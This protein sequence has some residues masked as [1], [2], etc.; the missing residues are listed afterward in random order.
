MTDYIG[1]KNFDKA[2]TVIY[3]MLGKGETLPRILNSVYN[4]FRRLLHVAISNNTDAELAKFLGIKEFA[5]K[6]AK[7][8]ANAFKK[9]SLKN[10]VDML[11]DTDYLIK[12]GTVDPVDKIWHT[13]FTVITE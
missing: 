8:Q 10:A 7:Q 11:A 12:T 9:K 1:K 6:K 5:V 3:E 13:L 4:Y 2:I